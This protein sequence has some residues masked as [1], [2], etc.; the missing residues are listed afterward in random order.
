MKVS[1]AMSVPAVSVTPTT[2]I[3][4]AARLMEVHGVGCLVVVEDGEPRGVVTDRDVALRAV[5]VALGHGE[6]VGKIMSSP[7]VTVGAADDVESAYRTF[8]RSGV[9]R[10]PVLDGEHVVGM[11]S[12]D[13]LLMDVFRRL[14]DLLGP[15]A[16]SILDEPP[17]P[18]DE[19]GPRT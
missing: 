16:W 15:V 9:R 2:T 14:A 13:D 7:A 6:P 4:E 11:L 1:A 10:L 12:L 3:R 8:R 18:Q 19:I 17:G 5:T